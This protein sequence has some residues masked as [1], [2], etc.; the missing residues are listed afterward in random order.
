MRVEFGRAAGDVERRNAPPRQ[1][2]EHDVG[3]LADISSVR[4][5]L[6]L[7]WQWK[8]DWLQR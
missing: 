4:C 5:G 8:Q 7:T 2:I 3:D 6:A 1:K